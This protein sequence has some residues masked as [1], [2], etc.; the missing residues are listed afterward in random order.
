M[1]LDLKSLEEE[2]KTDLSGGLMRS[3]SLGKLWVKPTTS[4][5]NDLGKEEEDFW[6]ESLHWS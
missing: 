3:L 1:F 6:K 4:L 2:G 5:G